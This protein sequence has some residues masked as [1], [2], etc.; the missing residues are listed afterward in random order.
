MAKTLNF[1][2]IQDIAGGEKEPFMNLLRII[3]KNLHEYPPQI[4]ETF[5]KQ[6]WEEFRK[7]SH[8]FK[9]CTA[10]LN[11]PEL[12][13]ILT[14]LEYAKENGISEVEMESQIVQMKEYSI[15]TQ[16]QVAT[17]MEEIIS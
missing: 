11:F 12:N 16:E 17:K 2:Y 7:L 15:F 14:A 4:E 1:S 10:Y 13:D 8:K 6:D 5:Q 9:S 3:A